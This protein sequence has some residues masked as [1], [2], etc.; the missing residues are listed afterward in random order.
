MRE[1]L[2]F[3]AIYPDTFYKLTNIYK[4]ESKGKQDFGNFCDSLVKQSKENF[5][6]K[7]LQKSEH[8]N[9]GTIMDQIICYE[10]QLTKQQIEDHMISFTAPNRT[11]GL[12][13]AHCVLLMAMH[14]EV[15]EKAYAEI[16]EV[17]P[18]EDV[19]IDYESIKNLEYFDRVLKEAMRVLP[20]VPFLFRRNEIDLELDGHI[21]PK[22][23][24][25]FI[26]IFTIHHNKD[27]WGPDADK[28]DP[29]RF[30]PERIAKVDPSAF[31]PFSLGRRNCIG[32]QYSNLSIKIVM[33][34]LIENFTF[35]TELKIE[36][37]DLVNDMLLSLKGECWIKFMKR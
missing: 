11:V 15:Q 14:P 36:E 10:D 20:S 5:V 34:K 30:L 29:D 24:N 17:F 9:K 6:Q 28:F 3:P 16:K 7:G 21:I 22:D 4:N 26:S 35:S 23:S 25:F 32:K 27:M 18:S 1:K 12:Q 2:L 8:R 33:K 19:K 37:L 13:I 31:L